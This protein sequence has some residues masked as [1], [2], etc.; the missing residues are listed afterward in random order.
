MFR[1]IISKMH[2][3]SSYNVYVQWRMLNIFLSLF[4][5]Y[6]DKIK[7]VKNAIYCPSY[8]FLN[9]IKVRL[10]L[11]KGKLNLY[12]LKVKRYFCGLIKN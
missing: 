6:S 11:Y 12:S 5:K 2:S 7:M 10:L 9:I 4:R 3:L 1:T 8:F